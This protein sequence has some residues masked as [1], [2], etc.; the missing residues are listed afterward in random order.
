MVNGCKMKGERERQ[1]MMYEIIAWHG[2][3]WEVL[4]ATEIRHVRGTPNGG[5]FLEVSI[6][7]D[8]QHYTA[9]LF[10]IRRMQM[11]ETK[12]QERRKKLEGLK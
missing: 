6:N 4:Y 5:V 2:D 11:K 3:L 8:L 10:D 1:K 7:K 12:C 9:D